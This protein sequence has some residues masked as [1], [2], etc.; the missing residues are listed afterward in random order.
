M[1]IRTVVY[2]N[3]SPGHFF[4]YEEG[5]TLTEVAEF[6]LDADLTAQI[7]EYGV[8]AAALG[9]VFRELNIDDPT[10]DW[11]IKYRDDRNRS[12]SV[13]DV[14]VLGETAWAVAGCGWTKVALRAEQIL[15]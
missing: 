8:P 6:A 1:G 7:S 9:V 2:L 15:R 13:G 11:A 5:H 4:G 3:D 12:L 10:A 14:V